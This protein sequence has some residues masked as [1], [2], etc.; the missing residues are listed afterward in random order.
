MLLSAAVGNDVAIE[1]LIRCFRRLGL[2]VDHVNKEGLT[3]LM[4]AA[5]N[6]FIQCATTLAVDGRAC[7]SCRDPECRMNAEDWARSAGCST[8]EVLPFS[9]HAGLYNYRYENIKPPVADNISCTNLTDE[10]VSEASLLI[11][12][13]G[14]QEDIVG[15]QQR[16][17]EVHVSSGETDEEEPIYSAFRSNDECETPPGKLS[18]LPSIQAAGTELFHERRQAE[19]LDSL[20]S[21]PKIRPRIK[22]TGRRSKSTGNLKVSKTV[23]REA[24]VGQSVGK[25]ARCQTGMYRSVVRV[26]VGSTVPGSPPAEEMGAPWGRELSKAGLLMDNGIL[27]ATLPASRR[28]AASATTFSRQHSQGIGLASASRIELDLDS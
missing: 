28:N 16:L 21:L 7:I 19:K 9:V 5:R 11:D 20:P 10:V 15:A 17:A 23:L 1:I 2:N 24:G 22:D 13:R 25:V 27:D 3:A 14:Q 18:N 8:P 26:P 12:D 6:G 4:V